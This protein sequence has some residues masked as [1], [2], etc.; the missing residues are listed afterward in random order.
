MLFGDTY[1]AVDE[2]DDDAAGRLLK[3]ILRFADQ[4]EEV[5]LT[6]EERYVYRMLMAQFARDDEAYRKRSEQNR[7]THA[8]RTG[9]V[10]TVQQTSADVSTVQQASA[11]V[12]TVQQASAQVSMQYKEEDKYQDHDKDKDK[13]N[14]NDVVRVSAPAPAPVRLRGPVPAAFTPPTLEEVRDYAREAGLTFDPARFVDYN[15]SRGWLVGGRP[16]TD[17]RA[18]A[19]LWASRGDLPGVANGGSGTSPPQPRRVLSE[20]A[21]TQ[22]EYTNNLDALDRMMAEFARSQGRAPS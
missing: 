15:A 20:Q 2:L 7:R 16:M 14:D 18:A 21:Y 12:S 6:G 19:R 17:W 9:D 8:A 10:S 11:D 13:D 4:R 1:A 3:A 5:A 22:R